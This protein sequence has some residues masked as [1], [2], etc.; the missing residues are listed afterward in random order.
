MFLFF[1]SDVPSSPILSVDLNNKD[2]IKVN[3]FIAL[4]KL[5]VDLAPVIIKLPQK[6][7]VF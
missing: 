4:E 2:R 1:L 5:S 6:I 7:L 3:N